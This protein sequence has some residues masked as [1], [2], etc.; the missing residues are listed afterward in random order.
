MHIVL[1]NSQGAPHALAAEAC[2]RILQDAFR[3]LASVKVDRV[4]ILDS[5][6]HSSGEH[7]V[8]NSVDK[9][10]AGAKRLKSQKILFHTKSTAQPF[11]H[12][13]RH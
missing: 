8:T 5:G 1:A 7:F 10:E 12:H 9:T 2:Y 6:R 13:L 3:S 4:Q 11:F